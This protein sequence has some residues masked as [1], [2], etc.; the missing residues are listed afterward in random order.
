MKKGE[1]K[2]KKQKMFLYFDFSEQNTKVEKK[3]SKNLK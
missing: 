3:T 2:K 1:G